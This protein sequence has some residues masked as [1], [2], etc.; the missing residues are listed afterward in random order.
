VKDAIRQPSLFEL[1]EVSLEEAVEIRR[2]RRVQPEPETRMVQLALPNDPVLLTPTAT[3]GKTTAKA[4]APVARPSRA[5]CKIIIDWLTEAQ[6]HCGTSRARLFVAWLEMCNFIIDECTEMLWDAW[7]RQLRPEPEPVMRRAKQLAAASLSSE[8]QRCLWECFADLATTLT[9]SERFIYADPVGSAYMELGAHDETFAQYFTC[10][11]V[12]EFM[13]KMLLGGGQAQATLREHWQQQ[14]DADE[15]FD[16]YVTCFQLMLRAFRTPGEPEPDWFF[17]RRLDLMSR[18]EP[19]SV[20]DPCC[21]SGVMLLAAAAAVPREWVE[22]GWIRFWGIDLDSTCCQMAMLNSKLFGLN[23][24]WLKPAYAFTVRE[25]AGLP[26]P[27]NVLYVNILR[28]A[29]PGADF[30][31]QGLD[32]A[33]KSTL[34]EWEGFDQLMAHPLTPQVPQLPAAVPASQPATAGATC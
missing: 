9:D 14:R 30:W 13:G 10:Y 20:L 22:F 26:W 4:V 21:G 2:Q 5:G 23:G 27:W 12:A 24:F 33:R 18:V 7:V 19:L 28:G 6:R 17:Y 3:G 32:M 31:R 8:A 29:A 15:S 11:T 34:D 1:P 25:A 16:A